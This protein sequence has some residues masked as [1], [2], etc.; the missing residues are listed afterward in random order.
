MLRSFLLS[1]DDSTARIIGRVFKDLE[2]ETDHCAEPASAVATVVKGRYD[3]LVLDDAV[4]EAIGFLERILEHQS[5]SK[6][7]RITLADPSVTLNPVFKSGTQIVLYKP[8]SS[9]RVRHGLRAVRNLMARERRRG[10]KR[11][12][13]MIPARIR[14]GRSA[15]AQVLIA[16]LSDSGA[17]I[18]C[19]DRDIPQASNFHLDFALPGAEDRIHALSEVVWQDANGSAGVRFLDIPT[20][21]RK[22]LA[23]W[24]KEQ[25][26]P[27]AQASLTYAN[28]AGV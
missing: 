7:V 18:N 25:A 20:S 17:L 14:Q 5:C 28:G 16:D 3:A 12:R 1:R 6:A 4:P 11:I 24:L 26:S 13:A 9:E 15:G 19:V 8:L 27:A 21:C 23:E 2:V 22:R 10:M